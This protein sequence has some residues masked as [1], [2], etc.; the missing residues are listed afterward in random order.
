MSFEIGETTGDYEIVGVLGSGGMGKVYKVRNT[1]SDRFDAMKVLLPDLNTNSELA[2]RFLREIKVQARLNHPNIASLHTALNVNNQLLM[3]MELVEG[4]N[5]EQE[6]RHHPIPYQDAEGYLI[7]IL[8]ALEYAHKNGV[9]H[10]DIKPANIIVM[11]SGQVKLMDFGI[12]RVTADRSLTK[13][14]IA[15]GSLFYMS[16]EQIHG[17]HPDARSDIYSLGVTF[18]EVM[19]GKRP[20]N[21]DSDYSIMTAHLM[22][23]PLNPAELNPLVPPA[24]AQV[25]L[26]S[27]EKSADDRYQTA[28][29]FL[30]A[31]IQAKQYPNQVPEMESNA[32]TKLVQPLA[33][34][35]APKKSVPSAWIAGGAAVLV[36]GL[37]VAKF[38]PSPAPS[39]SPAAAVI[40]QSSASAASP[41]RPAVLPKPDTSSAIKP[42]LPAP[43]T[44][45]PAR[46]REKPKAAVV[47]QSD[48]P[49][50]QQTAPPMTAKNAPVSFSGSNSTLER[51]VPAVQHQTPASSPPVTQPPQAAAAQPL[52]VPAAKDPR[53]V[54]QEEWDRVSNSKDVAALQDFQRKHSDSPFSSQAAARIELHSWE[55]VAG[56]REAAAL[57]GFRAQFPNGPHAAQ[58]GAEIDALEAEAN[59]RSILNVL[60]GYRTA[61]DNRDTSAIQSLWPTLGREDLAKIDAFFKATKSAK[62]VLQ[63]VA[64]PKIAGDTASVACI[65]SV[66]VQMRDGARQ[67]PI[68]QNVTV[69]LKKSGAAWVIAALE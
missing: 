64:Q 69:R 60:A 24:L 44:E 40:Q 51:P 43:A 42:P 33:M 16:P 12:A 67:R 50:L 6:I 68:D 21:G 27:L 1:F 48:R 47:L 4:R 14:G 20:I 15:L 61:Y 18:Y 39:P 26:K 22:H 19:T 45:P 13:T 30:A 38:S 31:I 65:R 63:P 34:A 53:V 32:V 54:L 66:T 62:M 5:L 55:L 23:A 56:S 9:I 58:A 10:R 57:R 2:D 29:E 11:P 36:A 37:A 3:I 17:E 7:Q 52:P 59:S 49:A 28:E 41:A 46:E 35:E 25:I 8:S